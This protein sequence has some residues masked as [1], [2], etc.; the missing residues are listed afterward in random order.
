MNVRNFSLV[1]ALVVFSTSICQAQNDFFFSFADL[2]GP[3][4]NGDAAGTFNV[5]DT[6]SLFLYYST[7][8]PSNSNLSVGFFTN[9]LTSAS[10][11]VAFTAAETF[12]YDLTVGGNPT[13]L[14]RLSTGN[15][16]GFAGPAVLVT[17]DLVTDLRAFT[18]TGSGILEANNGSGV[19]TD[20]GHVPGA[21]N[22]FQIGRLDFSVIGNGT[23]DINFLITQAVNGA[24]DFAPT[25]VGGTA[26]ITAGQIVPE[27]T[28]AGL[29]ALALV[30]LVAR[31]RRS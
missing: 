7:D 26:T 21:G 15:G 31:R 11:V 1:L 4:V 8:G 19:F 5:G 2:G 18:V 17:P 29:L 27:P 10:G 25:A 9:L 22:N 6:G 24:V 23:V 14:T 13:G 30:G 12:D 28:S 3:V 16:G 20:A